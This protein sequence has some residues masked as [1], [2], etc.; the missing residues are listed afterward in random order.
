M[1]PLFIHRNLNRINEQLFRICRRQECLQYFNVCPELFETNIHSRLIITTRRN[2]NPVTGMALMF[3]YNSGEKRIL[4][5][6]F[7]FSNERKKFTTIHHF[8]ASYG[9]QTH[10]H[11][12]SGHPLKRHEPTRRKL[13]ATDLYRWWINERGPSNGRCYSFCPFSVQ[14]I[15]DV[16]KVILI[17]HMKKK[18]QTLKIVLYQ[19]LK[20]KTRCLQHP[21][22]SCAYEYSK[23]VSKYSSWPTMAFR[24]VLF[25]YGRWTMMDERSSALPKALTMH[26]NQFQM[27]LIALVIFQFNWLYYIC[28]ESANNPSVYFQIKIILRIM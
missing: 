8:V 10:T 2:M 22:F 5:F 18:T 6:C 21:F 7:F 4:L 12:T 3:L 19:I 28:L 24:N 15:C 11:H 23:F 26:S 17:T 1:Y 13:F 27:L 25:S 20:H 14:S 16:S 9:T